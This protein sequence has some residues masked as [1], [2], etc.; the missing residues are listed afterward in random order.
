[1]LTAT[2]TDAQGNTSEFSQCH[3]VPNSGSIT[4]ASPANNKAGE[5]LIVLR[6]SNLPADTAIVTSGATTG[7]GFVFTSPSYASAVW[8]RLPSG[9]PL[10]NATIQLRNAAGTLVT[11]AFPV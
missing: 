6:G 9:F 1:F 7:N 3:L 10:G 5:G 11:N 2:L 8:V 4:S